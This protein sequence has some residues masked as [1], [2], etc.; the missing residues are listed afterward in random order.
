M[1][2]IKINIILKRNYF[3]NPT[4]IMEFSPIWIAV[5]K[6]VVDANILYNVEYGLKLLF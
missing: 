2:Y 1:K 4:R 6:C 3:A 5:D